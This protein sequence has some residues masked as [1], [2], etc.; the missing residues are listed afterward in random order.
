MKHPNDTE[1]EFLHSCTSEELAPLVEI[2]VNPSDKHWTCELDDTENYKKYYPDHTKYVDELIEDYQKFGGNTFANI[3]RGYGVPY[4]E[5]LRDVAS[6][7]NVNFNDRQSTMMIEQA[8]LDKTLSDY[9]ENLSEE[10]R[11]TTLDELGL[12]SHAYGGCAAD[13]LLAT[14]RAGG[15]KSYQILVILA[16]WIARMVLGRGLS[17][18]ANAGLTKAASIVFGP[19]GWI[20]GGVW[21][22]MD[23]ASPAMR[24]VVPATIYIAVLRRIKARQMAA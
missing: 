8:L 24:V 16:N 1:L 10:E 2:D 19:V 23:I 7:R 15:F 6:A 22:A 14:F 5:I 9:W 21:T 13:I 11:K 20:V 18:A 4:A 12:G 3:V 17:L